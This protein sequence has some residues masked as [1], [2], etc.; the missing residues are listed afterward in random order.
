MA[1]QCEKAL[2][3][4]PA[5]LS[6]TSGDPQNRPTHTHITSIIFKNVNS[7]HTVE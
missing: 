1:P 3:S 4:K 6:S 7:Y 2:A 5:N